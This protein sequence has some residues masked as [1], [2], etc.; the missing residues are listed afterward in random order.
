MGFLSSNTVE[1]ISSLYGPSD[2][3]CMNK[4]SQFQETKK[5][6]WF[7]FPQLGDNNT[8]DHANMTCM[9]FSSSQNSFTGN[10]ATAKNCFQRNVT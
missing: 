10:L 5:G 4:R 3:L 6:L 1:Q 9:Q 7:R 8:P 2:V